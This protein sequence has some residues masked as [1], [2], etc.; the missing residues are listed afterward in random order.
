MQCLG[1][2]LLLQ[3]ADPACLDAVLARLVILVR[4]RDGHANPIQGHLPVA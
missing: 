1:S 4:Q 3:A 2:D